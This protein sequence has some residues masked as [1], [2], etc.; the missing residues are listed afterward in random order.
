MSKTALIAGQGALPGILA[1]ALTDQGAA[2]CVAE[3]EGFPT[4]V[5]GH[6][7]IRFRIERLVPFLERLADEGVTC[8]LYTSWS[9]LRRVW[10]RH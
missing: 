6:D 9:G 7:P 5:P 1:K 2:F 3:M 8:L 10:W 4:D